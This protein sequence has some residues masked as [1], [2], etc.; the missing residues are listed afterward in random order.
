VDEIGA[1]EIS[2]RLRFRFYTEIT[3]RLDSFGC[4]ALFIMSDY[5]GWDCGKN[6]DAD[7]P[8]NIVVNSMIA[9]TSPPS[10]Q[11]QHLRVDTLVSCLILCK[12]RERRAASQVLWL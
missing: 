7:T 1:R 6:E 11:T 3:L 2:R 8:S 12:E 5:S 4:H 9:A 10:T